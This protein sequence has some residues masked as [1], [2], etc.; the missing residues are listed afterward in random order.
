[1]RRRLHLPWLAALAAGVA[2]AG[3]I[4]AFSRCTPAADAAGVGLLVAA[5]VLVAAALAGGWIRSRRR[6]R[7]E[8]RGVDL[9]VVLVG[10][11]LGAAFIAAVAAI[12]AVNISF[13]RC[14]DPF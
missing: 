9:A 3:S 10:T 13:A 4:A 7:L 11:L 12:V 2:Y 5:G 6:Q 8:T 14:F 1:V